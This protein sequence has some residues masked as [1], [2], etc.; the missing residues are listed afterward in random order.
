M[1]IILKTLFGIILVTM[2]LL[3]IAV[4][5]IAISGFLIN[6]IATV[7]SGALL[8]GIWI[9]LQDIYADIWLSNQ[10]VES[11]EEEFTE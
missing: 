4:L 10:D 5:F 6:M 9:L 11:L 2:A 3:L 7:I 8:Y 1:Q